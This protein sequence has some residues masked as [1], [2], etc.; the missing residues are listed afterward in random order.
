MLIMTIKVRFITPQE[1]ETLDS[2]QRADN[3]VTYRRVRILRLSEMGCKCA[4]IAKMLGL[5][6]ETIRGTIKAFNKG[7]VATIAPQPR[8]GGRPGRSRT[9]MK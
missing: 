4:F 7:G 5:H 1:A 2:W 6:V 8:S 3:V 9:P